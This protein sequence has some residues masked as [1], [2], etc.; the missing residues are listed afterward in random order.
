[1]AAMANHE[2][3]WESRQSFANLTLKV[4]EAVI[5]DRCTVEPH[6]GGTNSHQSTE[7][8]GRGREPGQ[9][10]L[11]RGKYHLPGRARANLTHRVRS[12]KA[13]DAAKVSVLSED[14]MCAGLGARTET[15]FRETVSKLMAVQA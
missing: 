8:W 13:L 3:C 10:L 9:I 2:R 1:M 7:F 4:V 6:G 12:R 5:R 14:G 11:G 15:C